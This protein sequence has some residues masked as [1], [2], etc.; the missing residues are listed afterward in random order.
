[1]SNTTTA[2]PLD[3]IVHA[4]RRRAM[5][6]VTSN[7]RYVGERII[8]LSHGVTHWVHRV[9]LTREEIRGEL[10]AALREM[11]YRR[12]GV[13]CQ[14][15]PRWEACECFPGLPQAT[16]ERIRLAAESAVD[17]VDHRLWE[18]VE[19]INA[20]ERREARKELRLRKMGL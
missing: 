6:A 4:N 20:A 3:V 10:I 13:R 2:T 19:R 11:E 9:D 17:E 15:H 16:E 8:E 14:W 18:A 12:L 1:M 7:L 5:E